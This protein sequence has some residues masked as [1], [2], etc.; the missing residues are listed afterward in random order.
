VETEIISYHE[1]IEI[2]ALYCNRIRN[3]FGWY[4]LSTLSELRLPFFRILFPCLYRPRDS[5]R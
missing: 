1:F 3:W 4:R 5:L 2:T